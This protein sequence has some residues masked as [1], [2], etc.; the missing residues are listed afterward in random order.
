MNPEKNKKEEEKMKKL[1][2][3]AVLGLFVLTG[4]GGYYMVTDPSSKNVY[5]TENIKDSKAG[6]IKFTDSKTGSDV[7]LQSSEVKEITKDEFKA[8]VGKK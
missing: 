8:G 5:Y 1:V 3:V 6:M 7:T 2:L 4:C